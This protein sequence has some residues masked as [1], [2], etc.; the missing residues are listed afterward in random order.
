MFRGHTSIITV[1]AA[2]WLK[3]LLAQILHKAKE[4]CVWIFIPPRKSLQGK[5]EQ[6]RKNN[7][8]QFPYNK[9]RK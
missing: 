9:D 3:L 2:S 6:L 1:L 8:V 5:T 4:I 7:D